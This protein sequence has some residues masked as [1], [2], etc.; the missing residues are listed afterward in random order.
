[1]Q[2]NQ[3]NQGQK[4][5][6]EGIGFRPNTRGYSEEI[7][8]TE[9]MGEA[10]RSGLEIM[11]DVKEDG[12]RDYDKKIEREISI[13]TMPEKFRVNRT[14]SKK[15]KAT[16]LII[17]IGGF[18]LIMVVFTSLYFFL[19]KDMN[20]K[21]QE[22]IQLGD[23]SLI[24][25]YEKKSAEES[26]VES[27]EAENLPTSGEEAENE[28]V[29]SETGFLEEVEI[30]ST[31]TP[32]MIAEE[33]QA[34]S[35]PEETNNLISDTDN[36]GLSDREENLI[37][38]DMNNSDSD[39][40]GY[41]DL[42]ELINLYNPAGTGK[43]IDNPNISRYEN[44]GFN[45]SFYYPASWTKVSVGGEDS[46]M[47]Q[48]VD[49]HFIQA[50]VQLN[51]GGDDIQ[52]WYQRQFED[53]FLAPERTINLDN[54]WGIKN[55]DGQTIYITDAKREYIFALSYIAGNREPTIYKN[56]FEMAVKSFV[57]GN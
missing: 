46:I 49:G 45:Y 18:V 37:G 19:F 17:L 9:G 44:L 20:K 5:A 12:S 36:D 35:T 41:G 43:I 26:S 23:S 8:K 4:E 22:S 16:G 53:E 32:E 1:M 54:W 24:Q 10:E 56:I 15:A 21:S 28:A 14:Q 34:T 40:D 31:T 50:I 39:N 57:I 25:K 2:N 27:N 7:E 48:S 3:F 51:P 38:T 33:E 6:G 52:D 13:H 11:E 55:Q 30:I 42:A 47:F 29:E